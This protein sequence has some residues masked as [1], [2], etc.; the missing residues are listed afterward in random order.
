MKGLEQYKKILKRKFQDIIYKGLST[1]KRIDYWITIG[2]IKQQKEKYK[3]LY[4][5][6]KELKSKAEKDIEID[7]GRTFPDLE[8]FKKGEEGCNQLRCILRVI[9]HVFPKIGYCQGMNFFT[10]VVLLILNNEEVTSI[11]IVGCILDDSAFVKE[12]YIP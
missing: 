9:A 6:Y 11:V 7:M 8:Y 4:A 3:S 10:A 1:K 2:K 5:S 12:G